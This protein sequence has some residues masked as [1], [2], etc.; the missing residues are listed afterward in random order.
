MERNT[1]NCERTEI[2]TRNLNFGHFYT[3]RIH[4]EVKRPHLW[5]RTEMGV[6]V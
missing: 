1:V 4:E 2:R 6:R 5:Q 3:D